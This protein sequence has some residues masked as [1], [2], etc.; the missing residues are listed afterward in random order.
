MIRMVSAPA[1]AFRRVAVQL[2]RI[3]CSIAA[4]RLARANETSKRAG[5]LESPHNL[6]DIEEGDENMLSE[7]SALA[8]VEG[9]NSPH[10]H[11]GSEQEQRLP[12][13]Q[14]AHNPRR[15]AQSAAAVHDEQVHLSG[16]YGVPMRGTFDMEG[17]YI[18]P[19]STETLREWNLVNNTFTQAKGA[20]KQAHR[21]AAA[22]LSVA[23]SVYTFEPRLRPGYGE[24]RSVKE[25]KSHLPRKTQELEAGPGEFSF[26]RWRLERML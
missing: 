13:I 8:G 6:P 18:P 7:L 20:R 9:G 16:R 24:G 15:T 25:A 12:D 21:G 26:K 4:R 17:R 1:M 5:G 10:S 19:V 11:Q 2:E 23:E 14:N 22:G 3:I